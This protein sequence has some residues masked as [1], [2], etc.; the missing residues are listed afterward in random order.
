MLI[1]SWLSASG[2]QELHQQ[3][4]TESREAGTSEQAKAA[5]EKYVPPAARK[6][7]RSTDLMG[8]RGVP[9]MP[10]TRCKMCAC[11]TSR[12]HYAYVEYFQFSFNG[13]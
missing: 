4:R 5:P 10:C 13:D 8:V 7:G 12:H 1:A 6:L 2:L 9:F 11:R 3:R